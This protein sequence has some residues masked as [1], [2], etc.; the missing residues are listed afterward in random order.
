[1]NIPIPHELLTGGKK[2]GN[3]QCMEQIQNPS[4][5]ADPAGC[6]LDRPEGQR[7]LASQRPHA[8]ACVRRVRRIGAAAEIE[9]VV[10][11]AFWWEVP[12]LNMFFIGI[13]CVCVFLVSMSHVQFTSLRVQLQ[14]FNALLGHCSSFRITLWQ[15]IDHQWCP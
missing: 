10:P 15:L 8:S 2:L 4:G 6:S 12:D 3:Q 13:F 11:G 5:S 14:S 9:S 1:M 7:L